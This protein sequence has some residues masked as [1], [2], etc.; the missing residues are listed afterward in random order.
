MCYLAYLQYLNIAKHIT[1]LEQST[2]KVH[3]EKIPS[4]FPYSE[5][6]KFTNI[7]SSQNSHASKSLSSTSSTSFTSSARSSISSNAS[8]R[9]QESSP[10]QDPFELLGQDPTQDLLYDPMQDFLDDPI[11]D[12]LDDP[13]Q[14]LLDN[15]IGQ[16]PEDS[17][18]YSLSPPLTDPNSSH[19]LKPRFSPQQSQSPESVSDTDLESSASRLELLIYYLPENAPYLNATEFD[20]MYSG[21]LREGGGMGIMIPSMGATEA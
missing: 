2:N 7:Q 19:E 6:I 14:D 9:T 16:F 11:Q 21:I 1:P 4:H 12:L 3:R 13:I 10:P 20:V 17:R 5:H 18:F 15:P 8:Q